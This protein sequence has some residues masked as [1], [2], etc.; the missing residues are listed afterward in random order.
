MS[1]TSMSCRQLHRSP[2][3]KASIPPSTSRAGVLGRAHRRWLVTPGAGD[4]RATTSTA[5][6]RIALALP[7]SGCR[8][9]SRIRF[10][11][12][13]A[14]RR[15]FS[16]GGAICGRSSRLEWFNPTGSFKDRGSAV[17]GCPFLRQIGVDGHSGGLFRQWRVI[18]GRSWRCRRAWAREDFSWRRPRPRRPRVAQVRALRAPRVQLRSRDR[19][20]E[21]G[22]PR[23]SGQS[24]QTFYA[25]HNWQPFFFL[26][27][28]H[29][30]AWPMKIWEDPRFSGARQT[31][32]VS[33]SVPGQQPVGCA[34]GFPRVVEGAGQ[35]AK[36]CPPPVRGHQA[37]QLARRSMPASKAGGQDKS[38]RPREVNKNHRRRHRD[39]DLRCGPARRN[40]SAAFT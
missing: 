32:I 12:A 18:D 31:V 4:F 39:Q 6:R 36:N 21:V 23:P 15:W 17:H 10:R 37:P 34:F 5:V 9:R 20:E 25:S 19:A 26:P 7:R 24:S 38:C 29:K 33:P 35:I 16:R 14:A 1:A 8:W 40:P 27:R 22:G 2:Q 3:W 30:I 13:R 11:S 28:R